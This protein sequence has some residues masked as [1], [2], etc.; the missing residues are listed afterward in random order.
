MLRSHAQGFPILHCKFTTAPPSQNVACQFGIWLHNM[1]RKEY[2][3]RYID[4]F[5]CVLVC[6][7]KC[8]S[9]W[10]YKV[11]IDFT[12]NQHGK[13]MQISDLCQ[14]SQWPA[15]Q[16]PVFSM[17]SDA[18]GDW[19]HGFEEPW[20]YLLLGSIGQRWINSRSRCSAGGFMAYFWDLWKHAGIKFMEHIGIYGLM[21]LLWYI[22]IHLI[23][24]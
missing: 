13:S 6:I 21:W 15:S 17:I 8:M 24:D 18:P 5:V 4:L 19:L 11:I 20:S 7:F 3:K 1:I 12:E 22:V 10:R 2:K 23:R 16:W 9:A 14:I